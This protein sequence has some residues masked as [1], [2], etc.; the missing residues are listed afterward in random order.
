MFYVIPY[1]AH[2][3]DAAALPDAQPHQFLPS[4]K[5]EALARQAAT[6]EHFIVV[7]IETA[8]STKT[9]A[10]LQAQHEASRRRF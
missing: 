10:D 9:L 4:A 3:T 1:D 8:W 6:H 7:K 2:I 5:A